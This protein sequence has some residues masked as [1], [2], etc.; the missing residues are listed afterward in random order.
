[1]L[2]LKSCRF[3][4]VIIISIVI[5]II[6]ECIVLIIAIIITMIYLYRFR[7]CTH[8]IYRHVH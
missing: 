4:I 1:M 5:A 7:D 6:I 3:A 2:Q 8:Q